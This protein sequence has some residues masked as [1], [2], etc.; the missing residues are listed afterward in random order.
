MC[1]VWRVGKTSSRR[2]VIAAMP[3]CV[4]LCRRMDALWHETDPACT[5]GPVSFGWDG[6]GWGCVFIGARK[7]AH[8]TWTP[9]LRPHAWGF[10]V[11]WALSGMRKAVLARG[12]FGRGGKGWGCFL[13]ERGNRLS[14]HGHRD[15]A[16]MRGGFADEWTLSGVTPAPLARGRG[17]CCLAGREDQFPPRSHR[18]YARMRGALP[19]NGRS[20]ARN[21]PRLHEGACFVWVGR[22]GLGVCFYRSKETGSHRLDT[23]AMP[24]CVGALPSNGRSLARN[25]PPACTRAR[26]VLF[27]GSG[28]PVPAARSSRLCPH[29]W[30]FADERALS[31]TRKA[32]LSLGRGVWTGCLAERRDRLTP[33]G[34]RGSARMRGGFA[35]EW[36][37]SGVRKAPLS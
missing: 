7:P 11:E 15:Y 37:L 26:R 19:T 34:H 31:G 27:G 21:R 2:A 9:G 18:G 30:G 29:A 25:R 32:P 13:S 24:A 20:L 1:A 35:V 16:C 17:V 14:P 28:R 6:E 23:V 12:A 8:T 36:T 22:G 4:G 33:H 5:R 10:A 3:A